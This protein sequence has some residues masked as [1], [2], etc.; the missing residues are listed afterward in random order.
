MLFL[1]IPGWWNISSNKNH[2]KSPLKKEKMAKIHHKNGFLSFQRFSFCRGFKTHLRYIGKFPSSAATHFSSPPASSPSRFLFAVAVFRACFWVQNRIGRILWFFLI[3]S[4]G[5]YPT[6][7]MTSPQW[8]NINHWATIWNTP[9]WSY[10]S[11]WTLM[12]GS[13]KV[14]SLFWGSTYFHKG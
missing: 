12:L 1:S 7:K 13:W 8:S 11:I 10:H 2:Q 5:W 6:G 4:H 14:T 3:L 9:F